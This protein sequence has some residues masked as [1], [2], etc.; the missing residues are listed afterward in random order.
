MGFF[1][2][3]YNSMYVCI[4]L[5]IYLFDCPVKNVNRGP[6][7][8]WKY[9]LWVADL[10]KQQPKKKK[11]YQNLVTNNVGETILPFLFDKLL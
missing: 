6:F 5:F 10:S 4:Y 1:V 8:S 2:N 11:T 3:Q 9:N 7:Q